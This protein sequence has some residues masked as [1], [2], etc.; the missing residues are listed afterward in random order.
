MWL[1]CSVAVVYMK[2]HHSIYL[3]IALLIFSCGRS[4]V[5]GDKSGSAESRQ[6]GSV[7]DRKQLRERFDTRPV[8]VAVAAVLRGRVDAFYA[9][10]T[11]LT[12]E[13][14]AQVVA[15]TQGVVEK[16]FVE[17]GDL[18]KSGQPLA[19]LD[20]RRLQLEVARTRTNVRSL[21]RA[22]VR[23]KQLFETKMISPDAYDKAQFDLEREQATLALQDHELEEATIRA[24]ISGVVTQRH[25]K[26]GNTLAPNSP[27]FE[28]KRSEQLEAILNVPER[29]LAKLQVGQLAMI[30]IDALD[31]REIQGTVQRIAPEVDATSGTFR[32][33]VR[34]DNTNNLL[35]PGM[36]A[37]VNIRYDSRENTLL[38]S[39][40][41]V[42]TQKD[43][44]AVFLVKNGVAMRQSVVTG[45]VMGSDVEILDGL[46]EGDEVVVTG[47]GGLRDGTAVRVV[48]L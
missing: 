33:T 4:D 48:S 30:R 45:Y 26:L 22:F 14:E 15:R 39:R 36:F 38:V 44:S 8:P 27:A 17:E 42:V 19:Q 2:K 35:R 47:Q 1:I 5:D 29:E 20:T 12:A 6:S 18:V 46:G 43:E 9:S 24:P 32:V 40:E 34:V 13:E 7:E 3:L 11:A 31:G 23:S 16:L 37:R 41:A 28:L 10:T 25:I 21:D